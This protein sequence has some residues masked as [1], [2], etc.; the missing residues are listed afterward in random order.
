MVWITFIGMIILP[1][2][3]FVINQ[4]V[5]KKIDDANRDNEKVN[6]RIDALEKQREEDKRNIYGAINGQRGAFENSLKDYVRKDLY[7]QAMEL[8]RLN[9]DEKFK[10]LL[11][12]V[13]TQGNNLEAKIEGYNK[14]MNDKINDL[15]ILINDL[16]VSNNGNGN[17]K[18]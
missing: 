1:I 2:L 17:G 6:E 13:V 4:L 5:T 7:D 16:K 3:G 11:S 9:N 8:H 14:N 10:S 12:V 15:K 18:N